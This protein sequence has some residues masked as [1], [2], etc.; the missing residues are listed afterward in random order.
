MAVAAYE[1][2]RSQGMVE[3]RLPPIT[4][5]VRSIRDPEKD[6]PRLTPD[7]RRRAVAARR[8]PRLLLAA[9]GRRYGE[10]KAARSGLDF[11]DL[12][13]RALDLLRDSAPRRGRLARAL[14]PPHG[15]RVPGH[16]PRSSS[17]WSRS[18]AA[19]RHGCSGSGTSCSRSTAFAT[20]T[21]PSFASSA[22]AAIADSGDRGRAADRQLSLPAGGVAA[23]NAVGGAVLGEPASGR[24]RPP[25]SRR[26][27]RRTELLLTLEEGS[28]NGSSAGSVEDELAPPRSSPARRT[29]RRGSGARPPAARAGRRRRGAAGRDRRP[30]AGVHPRRRLR[31]GARARRARALRRR[32]ARLLVPAAGRGHAPAAR[33]GRQ[34]A[35][36]RDAARRAR[37]SRLRGQ[38]R[39]P[40]AAASGDDARAGRCRRARQAAAGA[41]LAA[42]RMAIRRAPTAGRSRST[43][44]G[45]TRSPQTTSTG[46]GA[47]ARCSTGCAPR[48]RCSP[49]TSSSTGR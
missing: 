40:V 15:R 27:R 17:S 8:R 24:S 21:S 12:E 3:P 38:P 18:C 9:F 26:R 36:R 19:P 16:Q 48:R 41:P 11:A 13:L 25:A 1:R 22:I 32:R 46:S 29:G 37:L 7:E 33:G 23:V 4:E 14:R 2:L 47:S 43:R 20:P 28:A 39:C 42:D 35:R 6:E 49:S 45:S 5:P 31:G 30:A 10:L 44:R 34:P